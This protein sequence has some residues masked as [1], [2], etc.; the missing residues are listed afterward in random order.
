MEVTRVAR[1]VGTGL[2]HERRDQ[3][4]LR[5]QRFRGVLEQ[6]GPVCGQHRIGVANRDLELSRALLGMAGQDGDLQ[7]GQRVV[8]PSREPLQ[9]V[10][11]RHPVDALLG[12]HGEQLARTLGPDRRWRLLE[13]V[14]LELD[15]DDRLERQPLGARRDASQDASR[16][17][18][19]PR[20]VGAREVAQHQRSAVLPAS[21]AQ[22]GDVGHGDDVGVSGLREPAGEVRGTLHGLGLVH[23]QR[24]E[25]LAHREAVLHDR[26]ELADRDPLAAQQPVRV[27]AGDDRR[28]NA[29]GLELARRPADVL[30]G[31]GAKRGHRPI[32]HHR[33]GFVV[34]AARVGVAACQ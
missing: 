25:D 9:A 23:L 14:A 20:A 2:G 17:Q 18:L 21:L 31:G 6:D 16:A 28:A 10:R 8:Q 13:Q 32:M 7:P 4:L 34:S 12:V 29:R 24:P 33:N 3:A 5:R 26:R 22:R 15:A 27:R 19:E 11:G 30:Q 1:P